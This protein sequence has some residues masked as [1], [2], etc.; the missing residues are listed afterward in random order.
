MGILFPDAHLVS[1]FSRPPQNRTWMTRFSSQPHL[2]DIRLVWSIKP[3]AKPK[4][5]GTWTWHVSST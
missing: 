5:G 1:W 3:S 2:V 4:F